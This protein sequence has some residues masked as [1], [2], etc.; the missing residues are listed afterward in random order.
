MHNF[1]RIRSVVSEKKWNGQR[2]LLDITKESLAKIGPFYR[3]THQYRNLSHHWP[4]A[5]SYLG[6]SILNRR[7][8]EGGNFLTS[9]TQPLE[10]GEGA[11]FQF[12]GSVNYRISMKIWGDKNCCPTIFSDQKNGRFQRATKLV[13]LILLLPHVISVIRRI[14]L[15]LCYVARADIMGQTNIPP[16]C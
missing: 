9:G 6:A 16:K 2:T 11:L 8:G 1:K 13:L 10:G 7:W 12:I 15:P 4:G 3:A 5:N 14:Y